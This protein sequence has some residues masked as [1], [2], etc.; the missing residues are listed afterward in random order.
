MKKK[1][2]MAKIKAYT[3]THTHTNHTDTHT[4]NVPFIGF[5][6]KYFETKLNYRLEF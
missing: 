6:K 2:F 1:P 3:Q 4:Q 5:A